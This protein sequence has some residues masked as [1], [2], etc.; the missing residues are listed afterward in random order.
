MA[1]HDIETRSGVGI[2]SHTVFR[3]VHVYPYTIVKQARYKCNT[4]VSWPCGTDTDQ[5]RS[6]NGQEPYPC[7]PRR[8]TNAK[9]GHE[10]ALM[11]VLPA[12][13]G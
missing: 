11:P 6:N 10:H 12:R 4:G 13:S 7:P 8:L 5:R 3:T 9:R 1:H 2:V